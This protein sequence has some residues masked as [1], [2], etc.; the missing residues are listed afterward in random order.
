MAGADLL[1]G[2]AD[3][4][5]LVVLLLIIN[6]HTRNMPATPPTHY[7][8]FNQLLVK[9][10]VV[11]VTAVFLMLFCI[12]NIIA[13]RLSKTQYHFVYGVASRLSEK[14]ITDY[15]QGDYRQYASIDSS[16]HIKQISQVPIEFGHYVLANFQQIIAQGVLILFTIGG[17]LCYSSLLFVL[18]L[19]L[20][21]PPVMLLG[22]FIKHQLTRVRAQIKINNI[23]VI[24]YLQ[25]AL[26]GYVE[27]NLYQS[28]RFLAG[29]YYSQQKLMNHNLATQ[30]NL[31][32]LSSRFMEIFV[33][34]GFFILVLINRWLGSSTAINLFMVSVFITAAYKIIPGTVKIMNSLGQI[35]TYRFTMDS[36]GD[37]T[38]AYIATNTAAR[39]IN[40]I[41]FDRVGFK[42]KKHQLLNGFNA[43]IIP[44]DFV[45]L[46]GISGSGKTTLI[47]LLLGFL[48]QD[49]GAILF[50]NQSLNAAGRRY[51]WPRI[52]YVKQQGYFIN[53]TLLKNILLSD[54]QPD[55]QRLTQALSISGLDVFLS[56]QPEYVQKKIDEHGK[57]ISGGQRQRIMLARA[58]Y[59][60]FDLLILDEPF[61]EMDSKAEQAILCRLKQLSDA[62]TM[63]ILITHN[64]SNLSVC[65][66]I[67]SPYAA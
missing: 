15:L 36:L 45:G 12:K 11:V 39:K 56:D 48:Q 55:A 47:N 53:D 13:V 62:G 25:E 61:S 2:M 59:S 52:A 17:I 26:A 33:I 64:I 41:K 9:A 20:L 65:N 10:D 3:V 6:S 22:W 46:S 57:N 51:F 21:F 43:E 63:I 42:Y 67:W 54:E 7:G 23:Q 30:Q 14:N 49:T 18:L 40:S 35:K 1:M 16:V 66:K 24:Q 38:T 50:N 5:F 27:S 31:Q 44:G 32:G 19:L 28:N 37:E 4:A 34:A 29:R 8:W 58:L 60:Y